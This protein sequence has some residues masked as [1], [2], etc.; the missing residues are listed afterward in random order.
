ME[1]LKSISPKF[2]KLPNGHK[3]EIIA[4]I[5]KEGMKQDYYY[6]LGVYSTEPP[7]KEVDEKIMWILEH[8]RLHHIIGVKYHYCSNKLIAILDNKVEIK[9]G[10]L[11]KFQRD[12]LYDTICT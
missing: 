9:W 11:Y 8:K 6:I 2:H 5:I 10:N 1:D 4:A 12:W 7:I 3:K